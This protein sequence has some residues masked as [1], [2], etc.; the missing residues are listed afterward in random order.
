[1]N[2][3]S[4]LSQVTGE[5]PGAGPQLEHAALQCTAMAIE[6]GQPPYSPSLPEDRQNMHNGGDGGGGSM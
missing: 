3:P 5:T 1:V 2:V 4:E 6:Q